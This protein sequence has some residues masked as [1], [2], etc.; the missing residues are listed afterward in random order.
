MQQYCKSKVAR[1]NIVVKALWYKPEGQEFG[2][3]WGHSI[4]FKLPNPSSRTRPWDL[5][6]L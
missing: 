2:S 6:S 3:Q 1:G 5:L 4:F